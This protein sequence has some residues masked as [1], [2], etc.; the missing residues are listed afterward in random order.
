MLSQK[1]FQCQHCRVDV[2]ILKWFQLLYLFLKNFSC[3]CSFA[4]ALRSFC[5]SCLRRCGWAANGRTWGFPPRG[6]MAVPGHT[7]ERDIVASSVL[8]SCTDRAP[9]II[10]K[11]GFCFICLFFYSCRTIPLSIR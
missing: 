7:V 10:Y 4:V 3:S 8:S 6:A 11:L 9:L 1:H 5:L 2:C